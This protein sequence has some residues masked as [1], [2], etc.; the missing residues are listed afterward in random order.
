MPWPSTG[1]KLPLVTSPT[2][3]A[4][5]RA[6]RSRPVAVA[7]PRWRC[8][9]GGGRR[10]PRA[11]RRARRVPRNAG[12]PHATTQPSPACSG[13]MPGPSSWPCSGSPA[14]RRSVSRAPSP[15]GW[16]PAPTIAAHRSPARV[17][18]H[19]DLD[20]PL[21]GVAGAGDHARRRPPRRVGDAEPPDGRRLRRRPSPADRAPP[22]PAR[23]ARPARGWSRGRR[24]RRAPGRCWRRSAS[25]RR[26]RRRRPSPGCHHTM[27][28]S[29]TEPSA[30]SSRW[31]YWARP[32]AILPRSLVSAA[33][34]TLDGVGARSTCT[35]P[36]C[37]TS[38]TTA[39]RRQARCS[40]IVPAGT[41]A[42]SPSHRTAPCGRRGRGGR[43][44]AAS[45]PRVI[46]PGAASRPRRC[47]GP[48]RAARAG[49]RCRL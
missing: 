1:E 7:G 16:M 25:R 13:V 43:R 42:A 6:R 37:D 17:G 45:A 22:G 21:A 14:S 23:R 46:S 19:R 15:A 30:S 9:R 24:R 11:R 26:R 41:R 31:V 49:R 10:R 33:A 47:A 29:S 8:R 4:V 12:L 44:R 3:L 27:M 38:N 35:V 39:S 2:C 48:R 18:R 5:E 34:G 20:A 40:A 32:G 36:R 28:S